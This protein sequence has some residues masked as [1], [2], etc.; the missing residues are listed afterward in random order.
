[1]NPHAGQSPRRATPQR[2]QFPLAARAVPLAW[3][4]TCGVCASISSR[5]QRTKQNPGDAKRR[6]F[7]LHNNR[8]SRIGRPPASIPSR[9]GGERNR[10]VDLMLAKHA[11]S[12]LSYTPETGGQ[13]PD[14]TNPR[15]LIMLVGLGR[16]ELPTS[17]LSGVRSNRP[18]LQAPE[19]E[20]CRRWTGRRNRRPATEQKGMRRR[21]RGCRKSE[22]EEQMPID[23]RIRS[24]IRP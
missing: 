13:G 22:I 20:L 14:L 10:T 11:L 18:E 3:R 9:G 21:R 4:N 2:H 23:I 15:H 19:T 24:P 16:L 12:Q 5:C 8:A 17:R 1:M 7:A 6:R